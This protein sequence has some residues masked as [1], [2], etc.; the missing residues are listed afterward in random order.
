M[1]DEN[2]INKIAFARDYGKIS[3]RIVIVCC[4]F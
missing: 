4:F 3:K 2:A 1:Q